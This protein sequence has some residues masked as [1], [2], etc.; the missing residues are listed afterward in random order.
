MTSM[1]FYTV[2]FL[3]VSSLALMFLLWGLEAQPLLMVP[4]LLAGMFGGGRG[5][6][7][8]ALA[9]SRGGMRRGGGPRN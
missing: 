2:L 4:I 8:R 9:K 1:R 6:T 7:A 5:D 3:L